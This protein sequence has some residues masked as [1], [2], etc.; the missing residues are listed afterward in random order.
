MPRR[1]SG[2]WGKMPD[3]DSPVSTLHPFWWTALMQGLPDLVTV[4][5]ADGH[6]AYV[7][8]SSARLLGWP[9]RQL[10]GQRACDYIDA[11]DRRNSATWLAHARTF[12]DAPPLV[13]RL[14]L[15]DGGYGEFETR[16]RSLQSADRS[17]HVVAVSRD[18][19]ARTY[20]DHQLD[21]MVDLLRE[22]ND[23]VTQ[24][25]IVVTD[26]GLVLTVNRAAEQL[27]GLPRAELVGSPIVDHLGVALSTIRAGNDVP[28]VVGIPVGP[29]G[30][31]LGT[32]RVLVRTVA[33][34]HHAGLSEC[35]GVLLDEIGEAPVPPSRKPRCEGQHPGVGGATLSPRELDVL[36]LLVDGRDVRAISAELSISIH[37]A[38][39]YVKSILRKLD[40]RT[41]AQAV[42]V[43]LRGGL[44][45]IS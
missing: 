19:S 38:R 41:Q 25:V 45:D 9:A 27:L 12:V 40:V 31:D 28:R 21:S 20:A 18:V 22:A 37:T 11:D 6:L 43:A 17:G 26:A 44:S 34:G 1:G 15:A 32:I 23:I 4:I 2:Q 13:H 16:V 33:L 8:E 24:G 39:Y 35:F 5:D 30:P 14:V 7:S 36:R 3:S 10:I 42:A 29:S